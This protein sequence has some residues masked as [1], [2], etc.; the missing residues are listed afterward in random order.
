MPK[1][2]RTRYKLKTSNR[3][4]SQVPTGTHFEPNEKIQLSYAG[5]IQDDLKSDAYIDVAVIDEWSKGST[6]KI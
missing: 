2:Y 3:K 5:S 6:A 4:T 1:M